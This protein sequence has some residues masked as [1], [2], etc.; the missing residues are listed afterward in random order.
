MPSLTLIFRICCNLNY[1]CILCIKK[2]SVQF[3]AVIVSRLES[4]IGLIHES[5]MLNQVKS[6]TRLTAHNKP[7]EQTILPQINQINQSNIC[8]FNNYVDLVM[9]HGWPKCSPQSRFK[10]STNFHKI[11]FFYTSQAQAY[12]GIGLDDFYYIHVTVKA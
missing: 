11:L 1:F 12:I 2:S 5:A 9:E 7:T 8:S 6:R 4:S 3:K 10:I